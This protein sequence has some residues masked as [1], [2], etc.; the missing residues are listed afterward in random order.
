VESRAKVEFPLVM[1]DNAVDSALSFGLV[2][3]PL[4]FVAC[5]NN[6]SWSHHAWQRAK[7]IACLWTH[8]E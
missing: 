3:C 7:N 4:L 6:F 8:S 1:R 2:C 5:Q